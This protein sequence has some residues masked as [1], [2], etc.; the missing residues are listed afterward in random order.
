[1]FSIGRRNHTAIRK[2]L[3][4]Q[5][6]MVAGEQVGGTEP[7]TLYLELADGATTI[8]TSGETIPL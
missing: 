1:V 4:Q 7:R 5:G 8:K 6:L 3:W 2:I